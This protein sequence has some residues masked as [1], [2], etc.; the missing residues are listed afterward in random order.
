MPLQQT[1][2]F[3]LFEF[4]GIPYV[5]SSVCYPGEPVFLGID[6]GLL[7]GSYR[8]GALRLTTTLFSFLDFFPGL[9]AGPARY[10][11][12]IEGGGAI[13]WTVQGGRHLDLYQSI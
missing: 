7:H 11:A 9:P 13:S 8:V 4:L 12:C 3:G 10:P 2:K 1:G 5:G 6:V